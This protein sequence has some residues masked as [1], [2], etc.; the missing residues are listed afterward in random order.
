MLKCST[1]I[2]DCLRSHETCRIDCAISHYGKLPVLLCLGHRIAVHRPRDVNPITSLRVIRRKHLTCTGDVRKDLTDVT[3]SLGW[4]KRHA[5]DP[6]ESFWSILYTDTIMCSLVWSMQAA[7]ALLKGFHFPEDLLDWDKVTVP[8]DIRRSFCQVC[9][10]D[11]AAPMWVWA[12]AKFCE[13]EMMS[14]E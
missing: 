14:F 10:P 1:Q 2:Q 4:L 12:M 13:S 9:Q 6:L 3:S 7:F 11:P 8:N 5:L